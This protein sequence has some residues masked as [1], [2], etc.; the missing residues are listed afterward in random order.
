MSE[1]LGE[2]ELVDRLRSF[3]SWELDGAQIRRTITLSTFMGAIDFVG[4]VAVVAERLNH[5]PDI[6]IRY[7][8]VEIAVSTHSAGGLTELDFQLAA[9]VNDLIASPGIP[10]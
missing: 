8:R 4:K 2:A 3:S 9:M 5:H 6:D 7:R 1:L 10:Q